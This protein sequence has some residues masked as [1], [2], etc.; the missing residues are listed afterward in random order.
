MTKPSAK[1]TQDDN[2]NGHTEWQ[3]Q[4]IYRGQPKLQHKITTKMTKTRRQPQ[5]AKQNRQGWWTV[6][7]LILSFSFFYTFW[8][9]ILQNTCFSIVFVLLFL[10]PWHGNM[11]SSL[12]PWFNWILR[13][14]EFYHIKVRVQSCYRYQMLFQLLNFL[15]FSAWK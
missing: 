8:R 14:F 9:S 13:C 7:V 1:T 2:L 3:P 15:A 6:P 5:I 10:S 4:K 12:E 11:Y